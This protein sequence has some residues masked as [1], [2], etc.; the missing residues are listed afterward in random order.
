MLNVL[1]TCELYPGMN[2][3]IA[4][5]WNGGPA[6]V[7]TVPYASSEIRVAGNRVRAAGVLANQIPLHYPV[8]TLSNG[9]H[10]L[11]VYAVDPGVVL[12]EILLQGDNTHH[13]GGTSE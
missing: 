7:L 9:L 12:D 6:K 13:S 10:T 5:R 3:R 11:S 4:I 8:G 2:L 1:P